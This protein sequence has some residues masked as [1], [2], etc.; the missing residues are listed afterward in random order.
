MDGLNS[1]KKF[2]RGAL[3]RTVNLRNTPELTFLED[4]SIEYGVMMSKMIDD[5]SKQDAMKKSEE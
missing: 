1:S 4:D 5:V 2:I 3:A